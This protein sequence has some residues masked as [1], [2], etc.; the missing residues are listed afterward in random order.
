MGFSK[1]GVMAGLI[2]PHLRLAT[3]VTATGQLPNTAD[4]VLEPAQLR[5]LKQEFPRWIENFDLI[6]LHHNGNHLP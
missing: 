1:L 6:W 4:S 2:T 3:R 5:T